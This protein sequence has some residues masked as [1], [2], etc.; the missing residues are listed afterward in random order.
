MMHTRP[1]SQPHLQDPPSPGRRCQTCGGKVNRNHSYRCVI[2]GRTT[3]LKV[4]G[5]LCWRC[6]GPLYVGWASPLLSRFGSL[7][8]ELPRILLLELGRSSFGAFNCGR[9]HREDLWMTTLKYGIMA[10]GISSE[11]FQ[12]L[13]PSSSFNLYVI[14]FISCPDLLT[15]N[16]FSPYLSELILLVS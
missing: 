8:L 1:E 9:I 3:G 7:A 5:S 14:L 13:T 16:K 10:V 2:V 4:S 15:C 12:N 11:H 6:L